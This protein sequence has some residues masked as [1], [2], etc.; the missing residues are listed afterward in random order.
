MDAASDETFFSDPVICYFLDSI[1]IVY[2]IVATLLFFRE[3]F[4]HI[5]IAEPE[6]N[7]CLYQELQKLKDAD[8][9]Q[10][11]EHPKR[12]KKAAK[13]KKSGILKP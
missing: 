2:C 8:L 10:V 4:S 9:Y 3:K 5:P 11:L 12:K 13:K 7:D 6:D 1:L